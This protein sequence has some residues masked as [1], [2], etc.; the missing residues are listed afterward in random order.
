MMI[1]K[2]NT[3]NKSVA[4]EVLEIQIL[5]YKVEADLIGFDGIPQL[6][7]KLESIIESKETFIG[8]Y[9]KEEL[10]GFISFVLEGSELTIC[11][12]VVNPNYFRKGIGYKLV[13]DVLTKF[14]CVNRITVSTGSKNLPAVTL[15]ERFGFLMYKEVEVAPTIYISLFE[16]RRTQA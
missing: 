14:P 3:S 8:Y 7:D 15:Y 6:N 4:A 16:K 2:L 5:A 11:R 12:L 10:A 9:Y 1:K 13:D